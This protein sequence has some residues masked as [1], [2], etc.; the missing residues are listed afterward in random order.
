MKIKVKLGD[1]RRGD[2]F[3]I[4][5]TKYKS[6]FVTAKRSYNNVCCMNMKT[7]KRKWFDL[8]TEVEVE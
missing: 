1:L 5:K 4:G 2:F 3:Y 7:M 8:E 6:L